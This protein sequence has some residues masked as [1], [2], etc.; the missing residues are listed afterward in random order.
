MIFG[1]YRRF[2]LCFCLSLAVTLQ[3]RTGLA[4][5]KPGGPKPAQIFYGLA[6][7]ALAAM[8]QRAEALNIK[9]AAVVA[10]VPGTNVTAWISK[11]VI[12]GNLSSHASTNDPG[13]NLLAIAYSKAAEMAD[14]LKPSGSGVRRPMKGEFGWQGGWIQPCHSGWLIAAFSGG[15]SSEDVQVS[16]TG[17]AVLAGSL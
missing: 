3:A 13:S 16:Q 15:Q 1:T 11:M 14:T 9:G 8:R 17:L 6:D 12:V 2:I 10:Y 7:Q 4:Q 5:D